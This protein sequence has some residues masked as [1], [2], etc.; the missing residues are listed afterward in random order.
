MKSV[1]QISDENISAIILA[2]GM[3]ERFGKPKAFLKFSSGETFLEKL[4]QSYRDAHVNKI[5]LIIN[6]A[7][8]RETESVLESYRDELIV[9]VII[10]KTPAAGRYSS[11][12]LGA[13]A[14]GPDASAFLQNIDNPFTSSV[15]IEDMKSMLKPG[16]YVVPV[17]N[18]EKGHPVLLSSEILEHIRR[19][20]A[21]ETNLRDILKAYDAIELAVDDPGIHANVNTEKEYRKYFTHEASN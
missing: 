8:S 7:I 4:I 6:E 20:S 21:V 18:C 10:N 17:Y 9:K 15:L 11:I 3:S 2:A 19:V 12:Q 5:V 16:K 1:N 14:T 13:D